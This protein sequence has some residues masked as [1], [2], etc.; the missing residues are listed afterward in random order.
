MTQNK[1]I[2]RCSPDPT[3]PLT[4][5]VHHDGVLRVVGQHVGDDLAEGAR[6]QALVDLL[7]G[8]VHVSLG[9]RDPP[10]RV[11]D[12]GVV[13]VSVRPINCD[14]Y[15]VQIYIP[16]VA[17]YCVRA[18]VSAQGSFSIT[19]VPFTAFDHFRHFR[20]WL[21]VPSLCARVGG[22]LESLA[23]GRS[24]PRALNVNGRTQASDR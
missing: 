9:R 20:P 8:L 5:G 21:S 12:D 14:S 22:M 16:N 7:N 3:R 19:H 1:T 17:V 6:V 4:V 13:G 23:D 11:P 2:A 24:R 18:F 10:A 15:W